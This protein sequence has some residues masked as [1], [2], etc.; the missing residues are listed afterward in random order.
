MLLLSS[1]YTFMGTPRDREQEE[2][3][4]L[5]K[6]ARRNNSCSLARHAMPCRAPSLREP[7]GAY[8]GLNLAAA[9]AE[10]SID[11][12]E[13]KLGWMRNQFSVIYRD[14]LKRGP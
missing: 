3:P 14:G 4:R 10:I 2:F 8:L 5:G 12:F 6:L 9:A 7:S 1:L 13:P 11:V